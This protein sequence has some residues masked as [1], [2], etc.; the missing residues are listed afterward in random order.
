MTCVLSPDI[1]E[2]AN[3]NLKITVV[4]GRSRRNKRTVSEGFHQLQTELHD[5]CQAAGPKTDCSIA[6]HSCKT[7]SGNVKTAS[8]E[9]PE[10]LNFVS[11]AKQCSSQSS[12][13]V[14]CQKRDDFATL[15]KPGRPAKVKISGISVT[16]TTVSPRQRKIQLNKDARQ[17]P[18]TLIF[19]KVLQPEIKCAKEPR[20]IGYQSNRNSHT[21]K[22]V[23]TRDESK[24]KL[25][26][27]SVAV[28]Q[29][30]R[31]R[32]PSI[33]FLHAVATSTSRSYSHSN[34]LLRRSKQFLLNKV[35]ERK[36]GEQQNSAQT[37]GEERPLFGQERIYIS[38]DMGRVG[39]LSV[40]SI[41]TPTKTLRWWAAS[42]EDKTTNQEL[43][44]RIRLISDTWV[45]SSE[46]NQEKELASDSKIDT[47]S[48]SPLTRK[49]K[50]SSVVRTLFD[51][52]PNKPRAC[53]M[54][55]L[56]SWFM[57]TT[58]TQ[59]LAIVKKASSR[60]PYELMHF[61][62]STNT[63]S[64]CYSPQAERLRKHIKKFAKIMPKSP[65]QY[66]QAQKGLRGKRPKSAHI[67]R[68][69]FGP[70]LAK[71]RPGQGAQWKTSQAFG[72]YQAT[73]S[74]AR[75]R[76]LSPKNREEWRKIQRTKKNPK[77]AV[78]SPD[79]LMG[80]GPN[81]KCNALRRSVK[82]Q[83]LK[84][85]ENR[86]ATNSTEQTREPVDGRK[87]QNLSSKA[88]SPETL[89][90]CRVFLRKINS[91]DTESPEEECDSCTVTLDDGSPSAY[92]FARRERELAE[93][94]KAVRTQRKRGTS[95]N[96]SRE[97]AGSAPK[98][99]QEQKEIKSGRQNGKYRSPG[100][101]ST[102]QPP[103]AKML[104]QSRMRGLS[105]PR[106]CDFVLGT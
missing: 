92:H 65:L 39:A 36:Q 40:D 61:P 30:M 76:F 87:E 4:Y 48:N 50:H 95:Q 56:C 24:E 8:I 51:C 58:E 84:C 44:R 73:L 98:L 42:A 68:Q 59:S 94:V 55:Q 6:M 54:Q 37:L 38:E 88:W 20:T 81:P 74:R 29:S 10:E 103:P 62:R 106:W 102:E 11:P 100:V 71:G 91:P 21:D 83:L 13:K 69:L 9:L 66:Q 82:T 47:K 63:K 18:K 77:R 72:K 28:R 41:F 3:K 25:P 80:S 34:A 79:E 46:E 52:P 97:L 53:S 57:Q 85:F 105:G 89:K 1:E 22:G 19:K 33:H 26:T 43:A 101:L 75:T 70:G 14:K 5:A 15:R 96:A 27:Q 93:V 60:N 17:S 2:N 32:K 31:V 78:G 7:N 90:E 35:N 49:S 45:P 12:S 16:V 104:R 86:S 64:V 23:D 67:R 99:V